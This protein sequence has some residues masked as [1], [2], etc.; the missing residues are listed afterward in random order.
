M[1]CALQSGSCM[2]HSSKQALC[3]H[4]ARSLDPVAREQ[5]ALLHK[6]GTLTLHLGCVKSLQ[7]SSSANES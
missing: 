2:S 6:Q 3:I 7:A 4:N 5:H 1:R